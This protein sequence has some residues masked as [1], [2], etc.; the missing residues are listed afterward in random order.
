MKFYS[1]KD[2]YYLFLHSFASCGNHSA[3]GGLSMMPKDYWWHLINNDL[4]FS[5]YWFPDQH[6]SYTHSSSH[7]FQE[8]P[9]PLCSAWPTR[10]LGAV[11]LSRLWSSHFGSA[12]ADSMPMK[13][14][15]G[16]CLNATFVFCKFLVSYAKDY[17]TCIMS[18]CIPFCVAFTTAC[19][20]MTYLTLNLYH[21]HQLMQYELERW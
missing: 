14:Q 19:T 1:L 15:S 21:K 12:I 17:A 4:C 10:P 9:L 20:L 2:C 16:K 18:W 8:G 13:V 5:H 6:N 7:V 11:E 3:M